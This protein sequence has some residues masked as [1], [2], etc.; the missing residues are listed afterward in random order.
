M[1]SL[2]ERPHLE[3][4]NTIWAPTLKEGK[5]LIESIQRRATK[6]VPG[7]HDLSQEERLKALV[8]LGLEYR[9]K[10]GDM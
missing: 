9:W 7:L 5:E 3:Y 4:G 1:I 10:L 2:M 8:L 6:L